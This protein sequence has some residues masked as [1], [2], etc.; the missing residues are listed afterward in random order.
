MKLW[1]DVGTLHS[2]QRSFPIVS[3]MF[4]FQG[5]AVR[6]RTYVT[7]HPVFILHLCT[8]FMLSPFFYSSAVI[9]LTLLLLGRTSNIST[10][11]T[12]HDIAKT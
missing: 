3:I 4:Q 12:R 2:F 11:T 9:I 6:H 10:C 8:V 1:D 5:P 7:R